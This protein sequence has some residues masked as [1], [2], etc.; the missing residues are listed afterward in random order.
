MNIHQISKIIL[1]PNVVDCIVFWTKNPRPMIHK[2]DLLNDYMYYF[3]FTLNAYHNDFEA[4]LPALDDRIHT[5][6][7][8][9]ERIGRQRVIWRYDPVILNSQ[10]SINWHT[11]R[12]AYIANQLSDY[13]EK[14]PS[15]LLIYTQRLKTA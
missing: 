2:L 1:T 9:S 5:F 8:L 3:Q 10:Y 4:N 7:A 13:T 15:V 14:L 11:E 6:Q 12:F